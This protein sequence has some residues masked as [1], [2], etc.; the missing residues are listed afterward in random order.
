MKYDP[1]YNSYR[2]STQEI[3]DII[4]ALRFYVLYNPAEKSHVDKLNKLIN[5]LS[6]SNI[7]I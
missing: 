3:K 5:D 1:E 6:N 2:F 7:S 4:N